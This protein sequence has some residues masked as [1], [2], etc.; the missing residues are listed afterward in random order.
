MNR[1]LEEAAA[2]EDD[3]TLSLVFSIFTVLRSF[4][5]TVSSS[6]VSTL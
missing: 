3:D 4:K 5:E 2:G 6:S 1:A